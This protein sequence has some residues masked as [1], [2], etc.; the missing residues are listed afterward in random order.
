MGT[1]KSILKT[2]CI[3]TEEDLISRIHSSGKTL[4]ICELY[5]NSPTI[6]Q[7]VN[8]IF[9]EISGIAVAERDLKEQRETKDTWDNMQK[10]MYN[11]E[12]GELNK[13]KEK[14]EATLSKINKI[15]A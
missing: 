5:K 13:R 11:F 3:S 12:N 6:E 2:H 7:I 14:L 1:I 8:R 4:A 15:L 9:N 10:T